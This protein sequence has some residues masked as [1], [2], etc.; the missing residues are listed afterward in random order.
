MGDSVPFLEWFLIALPLFGFVEPPGGDTS[1]LCTVDSS[2]GAA[3]G[4]VGGDD[5]A[6]DE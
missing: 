3:A 4:I 6:D 5:D 2:A 1:K